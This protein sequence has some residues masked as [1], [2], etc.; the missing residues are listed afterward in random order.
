MPPTIGL[1]LHVY[2]GTGHATE[3]ILLVAAGMY[4]MHSQGSHVGSGMYMVCTLRGIMSTS[5]G[6]SGAVATLA[7]Q[8]LRGGVEA[9]GRQAVLYYRHCMLLLSLD[10]QHLRLLRRGR[11]AGVHGRYMTCVDSR[12]L[13]GEGVCTAS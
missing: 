13:K 1:R 11:G 6:P 9:I 8:P 10:M 12:V 2:G 5:R 3:V 4:G 7:A